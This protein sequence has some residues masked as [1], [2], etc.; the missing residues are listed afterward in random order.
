MDRPSKFP[1][2]EEELVKWLVETQ[3][4]KTVLS[5]A[6]IR[7]KAKET[8]RDLHIP[9]DKF[10][11]SSGWVENFKHRHGIRGGVWQGVG[12]NSRVARALGAGALDDNDTVL[13]PLNPAFD[14]RLDIMDD[15]DSVAP[16]NFGGDMDDGA[17]SE[18]SAEL[19]TEHHRNGG[20]LSST[21][22]TLQPA[23]Q[24][25]SD[26]PTSA[27]VPVSSAH[28]MH[29][30][31]PSSTMPQSMSQASLVQHQHHPSETSVHL[32][33][34][35]MSSHQHVP[36]PAHHSNMHDGSHHDSSSVYDASLAMYQPVPPIP[37]NK[38]VTFADA[39]MA[40]DTFLSFIDTAGQ[41]LITYEQRQHLHQIKCALFQAGS[42]VPYDREQR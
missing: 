28:A 29:R 35:S 13:S 18:E 24:C 39:E 26:T 19:E 14:A 22:M 8:A 5:D 7:A 31:D 40:Y 17:E 30:S 4:S 32:E 38:P 42:G 34:I 36:E 2:V 33:H 12:K 20:S 3:R 15:Q 16:S 37:S 41:D 25:P 23:W 9:D 1:E 27:D 10:K 21:S 6:M 11:A